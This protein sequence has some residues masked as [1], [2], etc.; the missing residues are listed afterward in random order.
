MA[1]IHQCAFDSSGNELGICVH[2]S[3]Q[4]LATSSG[5]P[6]LP[7]AT[8]AA[9]PRGAVF[10]PDGR[11]LY[12]TSQDGT[13]QAWD[14]ATGARRYQQTV[15]AGEALAISPNGELLALASTADATI[16]VLDAATG[17]ERMALAG[18]TGGNYAI[19]FSPD[20]KQ[21][22]SG[23]HDQVIRIWDLGKRG[24]A[25]QLLG[26]ASPVMALAYGLDG[27]LYSG[28]QDGQIYLWI[29]AKLQ[30][31]ITLSGHSASITSLALHPNGQSLASG[32]SDQTVVLWDLRKAEAIE[33]LSLSGVAPLDVM[34]AADGKT[35]L[36][37]T[38][39]GTIRFWEFPTGRQLRQLQMTDQMPFRLA[40]SPEGRHVATGMRNGTIH[41]LRL[42]EK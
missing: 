16:R 8:H 18:H 1:S 10:S 14:A 28:Y 31:A 7:S 24:E 26:P 6:R 39:Q 15:P 20:G 25:G 21:L 37:T 9:P 35:L 12:S 42:A 32:S 41:L 36:A 27:V 30:P 38:S 23:G 4:M 3:L 29:V 33:R 17:L 34:F 2:S 22:A 11:T 19:A 5:Q 13:V 40:P